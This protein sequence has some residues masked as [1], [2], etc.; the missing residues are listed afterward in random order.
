MGAGLASL[1]GGAMLANKA[2]VADQE[3]LKADKQI[4]ANVIDNGVGA[5]MNYQG[6][7]EEV[8][9]RGYQGYLPMGLS[10]VNKVQKYS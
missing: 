5:R 10:T 3:L 9:G 8:V 7:G 4:L 6:F 2:T 1:A